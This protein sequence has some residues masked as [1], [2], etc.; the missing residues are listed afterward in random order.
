VADPQPQPGQGGRGL[1]RGDRRPVGC[2]AL[3]CDPALTDALA[4]EGAGDALPA[5]ASARTRS[6]LLRFAPTDVASAFVS[7]RFLP[8]GPW[9]TPDTLP[10]ATRTE[11]LVDRIMPRAT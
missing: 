2:D 8:D 10:A 6:L 5:G 11:P 9:R 3:A 1:R 4:R 7:S